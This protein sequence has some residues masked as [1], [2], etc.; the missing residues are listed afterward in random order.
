M[1]TLSLPL[2]ALF[3]LLFAFFANSTK[4]AIPCPL[5]PCGSTSSPCVWDTVL[6]N[7][8]LIKITVVSNL[9]GS[10]L[11][12]NLLDVI[13]KAKIAGVSV[14]AHINT[15]LGRRSIVDVKAEIDLVVSLYHVDG[16]FFDQVPSDCSC[17]GYFSDLYAYVKLNLAGVVILNV[18]VNVPE[19]FGIFADILVVFDGPYDIYK[20]YVPAPWYSKVPAS[21]FWHIVKGCPK[22][23]QRD[24][25][26][27]AIQY[28]AGFAYITANVDLDNLNISLS[29]ELLDLSR[30][31]RLLYLGIDINLLG[32]NV[33]L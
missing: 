3:F 26:L 1:K 23:S 7:S 28:K 6:Q 17:Q 20:T 2:I 29:V 9:L 27:K 13:V 12:Q 25:L 4:L 30:L 5:A 33:K 31:L 21:S 15:D 14:F 8:D 16:I 18:G 32:L 10:V 11:D 19:C 22:E 24:A